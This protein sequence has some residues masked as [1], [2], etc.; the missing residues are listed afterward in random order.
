MNAEKV[1]SFLLCNFHNVFRLYESL[2]LL[3]VIKG[4]EK[5]NKRESICKMLKR[6]ANQVFI[7]YVLSTGKG[8]A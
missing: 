8:F 5:K 2:T 4:R 6:C 1:S 3:E 7:L